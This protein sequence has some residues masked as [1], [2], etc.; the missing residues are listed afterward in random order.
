MDTNKIISAHVSDFRKIS[1]TLAVLD[2]VRWGSFVAPWH[3]IVT[4]DQDETLYIRLNGICKVVDTMSRN[5]TMHFQPN[6][7][8]IN[9]VEQFLPRLA[10]CLCVNWSGSVQWLGPNSNS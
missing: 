10:Y 1:L 9:Q 8:L 7:W 6:G 3:K 2:I 5:G 4:I